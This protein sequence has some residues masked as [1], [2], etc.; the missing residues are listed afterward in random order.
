MFVR[1]PN[2]S[3]VVNVGEKLNHV[4][5]HTA[6]K[7]IWIIDRAIGWHQIDNKT[8]AQIHYQICLCPERFLMRIDDPDNTKRFVVERNLENL[9]PKVTKCPTQQ[10]SVES[11]Q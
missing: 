7:D 1:L 3:G 9:K 10:P 11:S 8:G 5:F 6:M 2:V 4:P